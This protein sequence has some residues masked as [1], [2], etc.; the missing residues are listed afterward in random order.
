MPLNLGTDTFIMVEDAD[1][2]MARRLHTGGWPNVAPDAEPDAIAQASAT[3]EAA[4][5]MATAMLKRE[6]YAA[7]IALDAIP[8]PIA[9]A[10]AELALYL[11]RYDLTDDRTRRALFRS[12]MAMIGQSME[13]YSAD[14]VPRTGLP[15]IVR[16]LIAPFLKD[17]GALSARL[18]A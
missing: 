11:L 12:R 18:V 15:A 7:P 5:Q 1:A 10:T 14:L 3:K 2:Y 16:E 4:L 13:S 17:G 8:A 6:N 9:H